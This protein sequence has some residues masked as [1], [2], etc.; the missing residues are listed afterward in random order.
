MFINAAYFLLLGMDRP[1]DEQDEDKLEDTFTN[2][3]YF[4]L[5]AMDRAC[6]KS[7]ERQIPHL[8]K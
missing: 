3:A 5:L 6:H 2:A 8:L 1:C 4:L 7:E